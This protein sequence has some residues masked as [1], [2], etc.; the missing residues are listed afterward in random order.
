MQK[1]SNIT[2]E[3]LRFDFTHSQKMTEEEKKKVED[4]VN[5]KIAE[6]LLVNFVEMPKEEAE[7]IALHSFNE[8]YGDLV[9]VY[10][11]GDEKN[12]YFS[13]EFCGGP[14]VENTGELGHFK[15]LKE[16]A[17]AEGIRRI[18]AVLE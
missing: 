4:I 16:E 7:K 3:R 14:H 13:R 10:S 18:K 2:A 8:K 11:I 17:V 15:I 9:K 12:G 5:Q 1:G 6:E